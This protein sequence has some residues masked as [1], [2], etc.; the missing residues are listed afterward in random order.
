RVVGI[1]RRGH[2]ASTWLSTGYS[3]PTLVHDIYTALD[4]LAVENAIVVG[5]SF[6]GLEMTLLA[7]EYPDRIK[8]LI[9]IDA[10]QDLTALPEVI[11]TCPAGRRFEEAAERLFQNAEAFRRTQR[12]VATDGNAQPNAS[13]A[14]MTQIM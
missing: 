13:A 9:Y 6:A 1:T 5:H 4:S 7:T 3:L 2:G 11:P 8:G 12:R 10:V 14:A